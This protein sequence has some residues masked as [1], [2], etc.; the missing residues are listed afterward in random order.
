MKIQYLSSIDEEIAAQI[1]L[2]GTLRTAKKRRL[3][4][5]ILAP[6][7]FIGLYLSIPDKQSVKLVFASLVSMIFAI[8]YFGSY[9]I[10]IKKRAKKLI[11]E[12]LGSDKPVP[13]EYELN[14]EGLIFRRMGTEIQFDWNIVKGINETAKDIEF[15]IDKGGMAIIPNRIFSDVNQKEEWLKFARRKSEI[16]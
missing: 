16:I 9:K 6:L 14:E 13:I 3:D 5:L 15:I 11:I 10:M 8:I 2:L 1:R 12:Q 4:G 7:L